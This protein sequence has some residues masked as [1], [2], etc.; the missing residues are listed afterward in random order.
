[1]VTK[2]TGGPQSAFVRGTQ[3]LKN[4]QLVS[5]DQA[6]AALTSIVSQTH[7]KSGELVIQHRSG[8]GDLQFVRKS[9]WQVFSRSQQR[10]NDTHQALRDLYARAGLDA[11][12]LEALIKANP[13]KLGGTAL[14]L[15]LATDLNAKSRV[16]EQTMN[17]LLP[18]PAAQISNLVRNATFGSV[19]ERATK[20]GGSIF[21]AYGIKSDDKAAV[22]FNDNYQIPIGSTGTESLQGISISAS[23]A[24]RALDPTRPILIC[25]G[26]SHMPTESAFNEFAEKLVSPASHDSASQNV[27]NVLAMN[28]RG[29]GQSSAVAVSP[30]SIIEDGKAILQHVKGLGFQPNQIFIRGYSL[31]A[32]VAGRLHAEAEWRGEKL[33]GVIYDRPMVNAIDVAAQDGWIDKRVAKSSLGPFGAGEYL[34]RMPLE[35]STPVLVLADNEAVHGPAARSIGN[36]LG[37]E[38]RD[39]GGR[40]EDHTNADLAVIEKMNDWMTAPPAPA[41]QSEQ[42]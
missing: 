3:S 13:R 41:Q 39:T 32:A 6:R 35:T 15:R 31:G 8:K 16:S 10:S 28:Y 20:S 19:E 14:A 24:S 37:L 25:F 30:H 12:G 34:K 17:R 7:Q 27:F 2:I 38:T 40:H 1:M 29:F 26:G 23:A 33:G 18:T 11:G 42:A 5:A 9:S 22:R 21:A 36:S 4:E